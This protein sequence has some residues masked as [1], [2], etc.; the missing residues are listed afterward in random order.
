MQ[1]ARAQKKEWRGSI[2]WVGKTA[3]QGADRAYMRVRDHADAA[4]ASVA[5]A[6]VLAVAIAG[7]PST[8]LDIAPSQPTSRKRAHP[9]RIGSRRVCGSRIPDLPR[10]DLWYLYFLLNAK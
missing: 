8:E 4:S 5:C 6:A 9:G 1:R 2:K 7:T 10:V 3:E